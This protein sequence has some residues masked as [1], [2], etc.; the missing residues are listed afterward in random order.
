MAW[1][2]KVTSKIPRLKLYLERWLGCR[3]FEVGRETDYYQVSN[4]GK[5]HIQ[6]GILRRLMV[7]HSV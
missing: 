6:S 1:L 2:K 5:Y 4:Q 3:E 7:I